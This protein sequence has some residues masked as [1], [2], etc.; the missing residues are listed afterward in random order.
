MPFIKWNAFQYIKYGTFRV[1]YYFNAV[2]T[3]S[4]NQAYDISH[5]TSFVWVQILF[6]SE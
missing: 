6:I 2:I 1:N 3:V 5:K 4:P